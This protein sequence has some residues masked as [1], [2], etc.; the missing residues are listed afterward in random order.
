MSTQP[1]ELFIDQEV[2]RLTSD[3]VFLSNGEEITHSRTIDAYHRHLGR[4]EEGYYIS[5]GRDF[6]R[7]EVENTAYFVYGVHFLGKG[8]DERVQLKLLGGHEEILDPSTLLY[9]NDRLSCL[10]KN[11]TERA[12]FLRS[13]HTELLLHALEEGK[14]YSITLAGKNYRISGTR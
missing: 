8:T 11:G 14:G 4:D 6:K 3:G 7:I 2:I 5:I 12:R 9:E 13:P 10:V 1:S